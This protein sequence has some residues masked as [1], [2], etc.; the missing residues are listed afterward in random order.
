ML[1]ESELEDIRKRNTET[2]FRCPKCGGGSYSCDVG[3]VFYC[4][5]TDVL[6]CGWSGYLDE[7]SESANNQD[8][9]AL[10]EE[11]ERLKST[12]RDIHATKHISGA[13]HPN[14]SERSR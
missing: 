9:A 7:C 10:L 5:G 13:C 1:T 11:V 2:H 14:E 8:V 3:K 4:R 6:S 12:I